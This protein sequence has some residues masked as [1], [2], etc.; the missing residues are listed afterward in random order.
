MAGIVILVGSLGNRVIVDSVQNLMPRERGKGESRNWR[1]TSRGVR[2]PPTRVT[3]VRLRIRRDW[4]ACF[5]T[6]VEP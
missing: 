1:P 2:T 3:A 5:E 6:E 4:G